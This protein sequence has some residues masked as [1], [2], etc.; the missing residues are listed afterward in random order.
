MCERCEAAHYDFD[1]TDLLVALKDTDLALGGPVVRGI[2]ATGD[3][4][5]GATTLLAYAAAVSG[6]FE[7]SAQMLTLAT[8]LEF[9]VEGAKIGA[10]H[11]V[12][13]TGPLMSFLT[14]M[15]GSGKLRVRTSVLANVRRVQQRLAGG[16]SREDVIASLAAHLLPQDEIKALVQPN[17]AL[18]ALN[19]LNDPKYSAI[20]ERIEQATQAA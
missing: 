18:L 16:E 9:E 12:D 19:V 2:A 5:A 11:R 14:E 8:G 6:V 4:N 15:D 20:F 13:V 10:S 7:A 1:L 3:A 17:M